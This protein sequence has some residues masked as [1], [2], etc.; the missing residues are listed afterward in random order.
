MVEELQ[1]EENNSIVVFGK[2]YAHRLRK[3]DI[4]FIESR[5][6]QLEIHLQPNIVLSVYGKMADME[7]RTEGALFRCHR[8]YLINLSYV[9]QIDKQDYILFYRPI[10]SNFL[11]GADRQ[12]RYSF[13]ILPCMKG[14]I[15]HGYDIRGVCGFITL[16]HLSRFGLVQSL[17]RTD[18]LPL[19]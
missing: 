2:G 6:R 9:D 4:I 11:N 5:G 7:K 14:E 19:L 1:K 8:S 17:E 10:H 18:A 16:Q 3:S 12:D 15:K 13:N